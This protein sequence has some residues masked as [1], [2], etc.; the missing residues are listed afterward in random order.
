M[1]NSVVLRSALICGVLAIAGYMYVMARASL[2]L[3]REGS[4]FAQNTI[5]AVGAHWDASR[6]VAARHAA[7][8]RTDLS[9][10]AARAV[11]S[12]KRQARPDDRIAGHRR[13]DLRSRS[14]RPAC[15]LL[16]TTSCARRSPKAKPTS[17]SASSRPERPG[18]STVSASAP[19]LR[20]ESCSACKAATLPLPLWGGKDIS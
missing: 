5:I 10:R 19:R 8:P 3:D 6:I 18:P 20:C 17:W 7:F 12:R 13:Q 14:F 16:R 1:R 4:A 2:T 11:R 15:R 9:R